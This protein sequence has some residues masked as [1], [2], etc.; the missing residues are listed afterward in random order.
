ML[1][2]FVPLFKSPHLQTIAGHGWPRPFDGRRFPAVT[3]LYRTE[4]DVQ[5]LVETSNGRPAPHAASCCWCTASKD[6]PIPATCAA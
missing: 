3:K 4:P 1:A 2:P 6:R 5:V